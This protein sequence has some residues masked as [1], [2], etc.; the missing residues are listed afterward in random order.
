MKTI[1]DIL[2]E[3]SFFKGMEEKYIDL[4]AGCAK[5]VVFRKGSFI[6]KEGKPANNFY[7]IKS[8]YVFI[9]ITS[10]GLEPIKIQ[11]V[12]AGNILGWSWLFP[13]YRWHFD[14]YCEG[15]VRA[16]S[17]DGKCLRKKCED[18]KELGYEFLKRFVYIITR[19]LEA[20]RLQIM[21]I[22]KIPSSKVKYSFEEID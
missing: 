7:L 8:G 12:G 19:R 2:K 15:L 10:A 9:E 11:S 21:D 14:A 6:L 18:D 20:A 4:I 22:Y 3:T 13:P 1:K 5:N 16:V 17:F